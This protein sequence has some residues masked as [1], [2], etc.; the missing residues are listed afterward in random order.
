MPLQSAAKQESLDLFRKQLY[1]ANTVISR[2]SLLALQL[3]YP[4]TEAN[5]NNAIHLL[6]LFKQINLEIS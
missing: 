4:D 5:K 6:N 2:N 1:K 3:I